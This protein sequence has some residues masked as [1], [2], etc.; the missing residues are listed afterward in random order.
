MRQNGRYLSVP[1]VIGKDKI[2]PIEIA[3]LIEKDPDR[4]C[5]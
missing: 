3:S 5:K 1:L 4:L 2:F